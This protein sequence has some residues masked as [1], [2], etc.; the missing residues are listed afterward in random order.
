[1][2]LLTS[3]LALI[4]VACVRTKPAVATWASAAT[5]AGTIAVVVDGPLELGCCRVC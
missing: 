1:M 4:V 2:P 3:V 5:T